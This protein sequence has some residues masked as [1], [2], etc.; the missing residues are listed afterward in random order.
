MFERCHVVSQQRQ[1][2]PH[3][4]LLLGN[5]LI[6]K[7]S[8][9]QYWTVNTGVNA[10]SFTRTRHGG[11]TDAVGK[12]MRKVNIGGQVSN[13]SRPTYDPPVVRDYEEVM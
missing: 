4:N 2:I 13:H 1:S 6:Y 3:K 10:V 8:M 9:G 5:M 11:T 7:S 12:D